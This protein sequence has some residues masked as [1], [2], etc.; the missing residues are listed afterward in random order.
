MVT[1][2]QDSWFDDEAGPLV[3]P[4]AMTRGRTQ[5][6]AGW[7]DVATQVVSVVSGE[8]SLGLGPEHLT[9]LQLCQRPFSVAELAAYVNV[10][11]GVVKVLLGDLIERG[12][13]V[14]RH[15]ERALEAPARDLLQAVL[16]GV[17]AL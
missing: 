4:Y 15:P 5:P 1:D 12:D 17:R 6:A 11:L 9:I 7:L 14:V 3:R 16:D 2:E 13:V 8:D 10:P